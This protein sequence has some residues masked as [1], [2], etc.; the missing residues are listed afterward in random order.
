MHDVVVPD[1]GR[2]PVQVRHDARTATRSEGEVHGRG[3]AVRFGCGLEEV[4]VAVDEQEPVA[5]SA[6]QREQVAEEYEQS[7]PKTI[8]MSP[9]SRT[10]PVASASR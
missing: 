2:A 6:A 3:L 10:A 4:G 5:A 1:Q 7:P 9:P 8:G